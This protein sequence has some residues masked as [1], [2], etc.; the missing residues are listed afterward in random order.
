MISKFVIVEFKRM[1]E[2]LRRPKKRKSASSKLLHYNW[3]WR[4]QN[5]ENNCPF[6]WPQSTLCAIKNPL[7]LA[8]VHSKPLPPWYP[9]NPSRDWHPQPPFNSHFLRSLTLSSHSFDQID[10]L[11]CLTR[12]TYFHKSP[13]GCLSAQD[14]INCL[15]NS[16]PLLPMSKQWGRCYNFIF[17]LAIPAPLTTS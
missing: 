1:M 12:S 5:H 2:L 13:W 7:N 11:I 4:K 3:N 15:H 14:T 9:A 8:Q 6:P 17:A 16:C 10:W